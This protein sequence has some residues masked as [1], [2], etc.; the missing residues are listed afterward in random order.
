MLTMKGTR[1]HTLSSFSS[2]ENRNNWISLSWDFISR[3]R[4]PWSQ[5][6]DDILGVATFNTNAY[7]PPA[8]CSSRFLKCLVTTFNSHKVIYFCF[9]ETR[10]L[11]ASQAGLELMTI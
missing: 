5:L 1:V 8:W 10:S 11:C 9:K 6:I 7:C 4:Y 2:I 3:R